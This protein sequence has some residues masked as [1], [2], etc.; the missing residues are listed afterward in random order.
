[1]PYYEV[2][3]QEKSSHTAYIKAENVENVMHKAIFEDIESYDNQD[4]EQEVIVVKKLH[5]NELPQHQ[6]IND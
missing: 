6:F 1:M 3:I 4:F 5:K 2:V